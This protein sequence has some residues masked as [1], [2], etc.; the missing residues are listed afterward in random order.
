MRKVLSRILIVLGCLL[1]AGALA[2]FAYNQWENKK[3]E[4]AAAAAIAQIEELQALAGASE[5]VWPE[6]DWSINASVSGYE[7]FAMLELPT[8]GLKLPVLADWDCNRLRVAPCRYSGAVD[9]GNLVVAAHSYTSHFGTLHSIHLGDKV[10]LK[11]VGGAKAVYEVS[12]IETLQPT[13]VK[14]MV[15]SGYDLTLFTCNYGG[16][17]RVTVRCKRVE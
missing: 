8:L 12:S 6:Q 16:S 15:S 17:A 2:L 10:V 13:A 7:Y 3:A 5:G 1:I 9:E 11:G 14:D 4:E